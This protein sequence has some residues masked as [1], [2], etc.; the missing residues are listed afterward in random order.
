MFT[1]AYLVTVTGDTQLTVEY[2][3]TLNE[4]AK[5]GVAET[6]KAKLNWGDKSETVWKE[7][8]TRTWEI[9]VYK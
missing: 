3:A 7:T 9:N 8:E 6:N 4:N 1:Q 5:V 2:S